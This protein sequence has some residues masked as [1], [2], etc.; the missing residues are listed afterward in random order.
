MLSFNDLK[1]MFEADVNANKTS[2]KEYQSAKSYYH[3]EQLPPDVLGTILAREQ[4]P[5]VENIFKMIV[6]KILGYKAS[7]LQEIKVF[8]R[9]QEDVNLCNLLNDLLKVFTQS[10]KY[11]NEL[12]KRDKELIFGLACVEL[13]VK[14]LESGDVYIDMKTL[15]PESFVID[16]FSIE[17]N[18]SDA[19]R[20]HKAINLSL[21]E[22]KKLFGDNVYVDSADEV[23]SR[24]SIIESWVKEIIDKKEVFSRY[25][26]NYNAGVYKYEQSPFKNGAHPFV[27]AKYQIDEK[28]RWY[29]LFRDIKPLQDYINFAENKMANMMGSMKAFFEDGAV[30]DVDE[31]VKEASFDNAIVK[32][33]SGALTGQKIHFVQQNSN[34]QMLSQKTN[35]KRELAKI[36]SGLN[37]EALGTAINRQSGVAIAQRRDAGVMGLSEYLSIAEEMDKEIFSK[38]ISFIEHY[39]TKAQSFRIVDKKVG[40]RYFSINENEKNKIY[41][42]EFDIGLQTQ[43]KTQGQEERV[44]QWSEMLKT[45]API[46]PDLVARI[47]PLML[48]DINSPI[49]SEMQDL[50]MQVDEEQAKIAQEQSQVQDLQEQKLIADIKETQAKAIKYQTQA[51]VAQSIAVQNAQA[52]NNEKVKTPRAKGLD[53]R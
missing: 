47:L 15:S 51:N 4:S 28:L 12:I 10:K 46:R 5:V 7:A 2:L 31:F 45:I 22:A 52:T 14:S 21:Y 38:V 36:L 13:W 26:W 20:F 9:Q 6:N 27:I 35:E 30:L 32:V 48:K 44:V 39:F 37:D 16:K 25:L 34:I 41:I 23:D 53:L 8:P 18:A 40:Q 49:A 24:V 19:R 3:G 43:L 17:T 50:I 33:A 1:L 29:G 42:G 11:N